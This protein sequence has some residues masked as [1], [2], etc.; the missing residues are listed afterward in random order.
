M[1]KVKGVPGAE[2]VMREIG[3][4]IQG[5]SWTLVPN[6]SAW[7]GMFETCMLALALGCTV[8]WSIKMMINA[9]PALSPHISKFLFQAEMF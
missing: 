5:D 8:D 1:E 9:W 3:F 2:N 4:V 7:D 6:A